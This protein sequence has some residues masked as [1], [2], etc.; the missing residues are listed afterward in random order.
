MVG[1]KR[2]EARHSK[3][4]EEEDNMKA[5]AGAR[6]SKSR[7]LQDNRLPGHRMKADSCSRQEE[8]V[9]QAAHQAIFTT[10]NRSRDVTFLSTAE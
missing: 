2:L 1:S 9:R 8:R 4:A 5:A 3:T 7:P 10:K 6:G